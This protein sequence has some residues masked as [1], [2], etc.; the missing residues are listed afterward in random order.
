MKTTDAGRENSKAQRTWWDVLWLG[1]APKGGRTWW[2]LEQF[3]SLLSLACLV[4]VLIFFLAG[5]F[6][7]WL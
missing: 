1:R 6:L 3:S 2:E 4:A 5:K 7:G